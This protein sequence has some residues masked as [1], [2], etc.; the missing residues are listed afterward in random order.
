MSS[1]KKLEQQIQADLEYILNRFT[2]NH[3]FRE[4]YKYSLLP[5]GKFFRPKLVYATAFDHNNYFFSDQPIDDLRIFACSIEIH[6]AYTLIHDDLP[7]MDDDNFRR[8]RK[9]THYE[10]GEWQALLAGDGLLNL[11]YQLLFK[12][13]SPHAQLLGR[14]Y[15]W[16]L[17]AKGLIHGQALDLENEKKS[18]RGTL[19]THHYKTAKLIQTA[20]VG[21][22]ILEHSE[23]SLSM[24]TLKKFHR[25]G[26]C[27]GVAFQLLDDLTE[28]QEGITGHELIV[29]P[30]I[31]EDLNTL[32]HTLQKYLQYIQQNQGRGALKE[33]LKEYFTKIKES[34]DIDVTSK[35]IASLCRNKTSK[36]SIKQ[37]LSPLVLLLNRLG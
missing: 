35:S 17:G 16:N 25:F 24:K 12:L 7:C 34:V 30:W 33:I 19:E 32:K 23:N 8:G 18:L 11:S 2:P 6:H 31:T 5:G 14:Y 3:K 37:S 10:Y 27:L 29:N 28:L 9:S 13:K 20:L 15:S 4:I 26:H 21:A 22:I 1:T 36:E